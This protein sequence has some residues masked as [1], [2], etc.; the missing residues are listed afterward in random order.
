[1]INVP[2]Y[3]IISKYGHLFYLEC[4]ENQLN[5]NGAQRNV[6]IAN[7]NVEETKGID[8]IRNVFNLQLLESRHKN[9]YEEYK[10]DKLANTT[11]IS[12]NKRDLGVIT[13]SFIH[14]CN[15]STNDL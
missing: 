6:D 12:C 7:K 13:V 14:L 15:N 3:C 9:K 1:M 5:E 2:V 11:T 10:H 8:E 4:L